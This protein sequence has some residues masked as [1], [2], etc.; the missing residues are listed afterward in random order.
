VVKVTETKK[1]RTTIYT[2]EWE[3][4]GT[5]IEAVKS[6]SPFDGV[7]YDLTGRKT[8]SPAK[9]VFI[10]NGRKVVIR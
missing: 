10:T 4:S 5:G 1:S 8:T 2:L 6:D 7:Y 3:S 9:G